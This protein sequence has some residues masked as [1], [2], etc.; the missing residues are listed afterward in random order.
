[1]RYQWR[2]SNDYAIFSSRVRMS[3]KLFDIRKCRKPHQPTH[4]RTQ[5]SLNEEP[6]I[7]GSQTFSV[8]KVLKQHN[9]Q[10]SR[11]Q[12]HKLRGLVEESFFSRT[13]QCKHYLSMV[14]LR[15]AGRRSKNTQPNRTRTH[16]EGLRYTTYIE[17]SC[18][19]VPTLAVPWNTSLKPC[20]CSTSC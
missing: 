15:G 7:G 18:S 1:M 13:V 6:H 9:P 14:H 17:V 12:Q 4:T 5:T 8:H 19:E 20:G 11:V 16:A 2:T 3:E 10:P